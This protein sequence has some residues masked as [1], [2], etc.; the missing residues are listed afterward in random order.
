MSPF[1]RDTAVAD[2]FRR[3]RSLCPPGPPRAQTLAGEGGAAAA[4]EAT[5]IDMSAA[6]HGARTVE[7]SSRL[8]HAVKQAAS[9]VLHQRASAPWQVVPH[10][11]SETLG[12]QLE[13]LVVDRAAAVQSVG[14]ACYPKKHLARLQHSTSD[15]CSRAVPGSPVESAQ[16][17]PWPGTAAPWQQVCSTSGC[18]CVAAGGQARASS[19]P[20]SWQGVATAVAPLRVT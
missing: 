6:W 1:V 13:G 12:Q 3:Q 15:G 4:G 5:S 11:R 9:S 16:S 14:V 20:S 2:V 7:T 8:S 17:C 19:S 18:L 10:R